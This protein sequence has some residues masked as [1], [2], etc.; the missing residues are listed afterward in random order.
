MAGAPVAEQSGALS[1][2]T[3]YGLY[4]VCRSL[5]RLQDAGT[6]FTC[7]TSP[8][9]LEIVTLAELLQGPSFSISSACSTGA[10]CIGVGMEQIQ[11]L[12]LLA[13]R[14]QKHKY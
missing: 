2:D 10:H 9:V 8:K 14:V 5:Y 4:R 6:R 3:L 13:L 11:V 12:N 7:F 1:R